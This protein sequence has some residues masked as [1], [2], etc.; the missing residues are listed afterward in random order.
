MIR[1]MLDGEEVTR[2]GLVRVERASVWE[3]PQ[4]TPLL[5]AP[6][7]TQASAKRSAEWADGLITV[8]QQPDHLLGMLDAYRSAGGRGKAILQVHLSWAQTEPEAQAIAREQWRNNTYQPPVSSDLPTVDHFEVLG[9][10]TSLEQLRQSVLISADPSRHAAWLHEFIELGFDE[11]FLH[12]VGV[13]QGR[14]I[15]VFADTV[16]P[17]LTD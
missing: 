10:H 9:A 1:R 5:I 8:N 12:H 16:L 17:Q 13:H 2:D 4:V 14:F 7:L 15:D 11:I 6:A 3:V